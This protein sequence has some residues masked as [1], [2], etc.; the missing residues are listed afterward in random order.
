MYPSPVGFQNTDAWLRKIA[1][2]T[3]KE[4]EAEMVIEEEHKKWGPRMDVIRKEFEN[5]KGSGKK[6]EMLGA[7]G[8]GRLLSQL[9]YFDELGIK[10]SAALSQDYDNL[11]L[12]DLEKVVEQV[13]EFNILINTFQSCRTGSYHQDVKPGY[14]SYL[15]VPRECLQAKQ[16]CYSYPC[17]EV[18]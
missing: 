1:E 9:P 5:F 15:P 16:R 14:H 11:I 2:Y 3:G 8:Q 10:S 13:G 6:I 17:S 7:L 4:R 18:R 12:E